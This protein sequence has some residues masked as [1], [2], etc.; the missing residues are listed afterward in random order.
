MSYE[1][2]HESRVKKKGSGIRNCVFHETYS[3]LDTIQFFMF[4]MAGS[5]P[6]LSR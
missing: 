5:S 1:A 2:R 3:V 4:L 6:E